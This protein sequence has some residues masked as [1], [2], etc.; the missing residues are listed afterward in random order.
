MAG[1]AGLLFILTSMVAGPAQSAAPDAVGDWH[2]I[3]DLGPGELT[4][5][6]SMRRDTEGRLSGELE[7]VDQAPGRKIP[8]ADVSADGGVLRFDVPLVDGGFA[9]SWSDPA[10][11]WVG[12][13]SQGGRNLPLSLRAGLP[14]APSLIDGLDGT[15]TGSIDRGGATNRLTLRIETKDGGTHARF[16]APD[17]GV[18]NALP[19]E[20]LTRDGDH[21]SFTIPVVPAAFAGTLSGDT[22]AGSWTFRQRA[23]SP[24]TLTRIKRTAEPDARHRPQTPKPPFPYRAEEVSFTNSSATDV[25]L[26]GTLTLPMEDG[27][28]PA[29]VLISGSGPQDRDETLFDHKPFAV[30]AH[31][32]TQRGIAVLR[33]DDR[34]VGTSTGDFASATTAD[35]ATDVR[36]AIDYLH[37]RPE[38]SAEHI[39]LIGHSEGA[40]TGAIAADGRDDVAFLVM[41]AGPGT[42]TMELL[43]S[44]QRLIGLSVGKTEMQIAAEQ[45]I[46]RSV[47][48]AISAAPDEAAAKA[49]AVNLLTPEAIVTLGVEP[50]QQ[51]M[52]VNQ[53]TSDWFR[54]LLAF[55]PADVLRRIDIPV[56][57]LNGSLDRQV[58]ADANLAAIE[59]GLRHNDDVTTVKLDGL[60]HLFQTAETGALGEYVD[61][62]ETVSPIVLEQVGNWIEKRV[63]RP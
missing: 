54:Y 25:R 28:F 47:F 35:F 20:E 52:I 21:V 7:S 56:L 9:G 51:A 26:A 63:T 18:V 57:A 30:L 61:I 55:K 58:P 19:V 16:E 32:L 4:L 48:A 39:G 60:N 24:G 62:E 15:W 29:A 34:G 42:A 10:G 49:A 59:A 53:V 43:L 41:L 27:P 6:V 17:Y 46:M 40:L 22:L 23:S 37:T 14:E 31:E 38:I 45:E 33:F 5:I 1:F 36:A 50:D 2:G 44:Q 11:A 8:I 12:E 3:L 13:W